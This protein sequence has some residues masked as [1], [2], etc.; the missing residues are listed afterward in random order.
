[1]NEDNYRPS[2]FAGCTRERLFVVSG[3][4]GGGKSTLIS[5]LA[6]RDYRVFPEPGRQIVREQA[7]LGGDAVPW[8]N[9]ERF[10][11]QCVVRSLHFHTLAKAE[12]RPVFFD[13]CLI[14]A[15]SALDALG[16]PV[17][18]GYRTAVNRC[19]YAPV[20]FIAPPWEELYRSDGER[21]HAFSSAV[22]EYERLLDT[23]PTHGY[24]PVILPKTTVANRADFIEA[25]LKRRRHLPTASMC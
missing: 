14:D 1:M 6:R 20:V 11:E 9:M 18:A 16:H 17:P 13:R 23:F 15:V 19:R 2:R 5:E 4:S 12:D 10:I 3:C 7:L 22:E 8:A 25:E 24:E 21:R